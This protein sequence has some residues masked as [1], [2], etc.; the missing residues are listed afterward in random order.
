[1]PSLYLYISIGR[2]HAVYKVDEELVEGY[3]RV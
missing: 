3:F 2:S 1:M